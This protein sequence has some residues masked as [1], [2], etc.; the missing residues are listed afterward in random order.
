MQGQHVAVPDEQLPPIE[1]ATVWLAGH[2]APE[3]FE[4]ALDDGTP[5][6][7]VSGVRRM[8]SRQWSRQDRRSERVS[9][10][11]TGLRLT[12]TGS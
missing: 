5:L 2:A 9:S 4:V 7:Q 6:L 3:P 11:T 10:G 12:S 8:E 1:V